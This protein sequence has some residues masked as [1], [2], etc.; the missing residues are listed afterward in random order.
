M[1][2]SSDFCVCR[3]GQVEYHHLLVK[4]RKFLGAVTAIENYEL[5]TASKGARGAGD[6]GGVAMQSLISEERGQYQVR[7][8]LCVLYGGLSPGPVSPPYPTVVTPTRRTK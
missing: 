7:L 2:S 8:L 5:E 1:C 6:A 3:R 4:A